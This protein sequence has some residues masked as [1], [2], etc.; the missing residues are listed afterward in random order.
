MITFADFKRM[1]TRELLQVALVS[2]TTKDRLV[3]LEAAHAKAL[4][5]FG[6]EQ[7]RTRP[8]L[9]IITA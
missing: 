7:S 8:S 5:E 2:E 6:D 4:E 3:A 1:D 9:R